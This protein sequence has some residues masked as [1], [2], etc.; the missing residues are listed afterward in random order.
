[1]LSVGQHSP[2]LVPWHSLVGLLYPLLFIHPYPTVTSSRSQSCGS[3]AFVKDILLGLINII[4]S[5]RWLGVY[6]VTALAICLLEKQTHLNKVLVNVLS[7]VSFQS[8][9]QGKAFQGKTL[10]T[11]MVWQHHSELVT[12]YTWMSLIC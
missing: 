12:L 8:E 5:C 1:M 4:V 3:Q 11:L 7:L 10:C 9:N 2:V 6:T